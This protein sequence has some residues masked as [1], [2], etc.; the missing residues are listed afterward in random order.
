MTIDYEYVVAC[1][2]A[3]VN[4]VDQYVDEMV[5]HEDDVTACD[6][7]SPARIEDFRIYLN[8]YVEAML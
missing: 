3:L 2:A 5:E 8:Q 7:D 4:I 1:R 6:A